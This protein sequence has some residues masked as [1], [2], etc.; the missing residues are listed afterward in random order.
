LT[1]ARLLRF[2]LEISFGPLMVGVVGAVVLFEIV[3]CV[4]AA[5]RRRT[6]RPL[7]LRVHA[8]A[9]AAIGA[10]PIAIGI[11]VHGAR[12]MAMRAMRGE[13]NP[14]GD[15][16]ALASG[17]TAQT[18][19]IAIA[20]GAIALALAFWLAGLALTRGAFRRA[21]AFESG[22]LGG[23]PNP[24]AMIR[25]EQSSPAPHANSPAA[26]VALGLLP[27]AFGAW[28]WTRDVG[29]PFDALET[30]PDEPSRVAIVSRS[31][32]AARA[33]L[34]SAAHLS[35]VAISILAVVAL[36]WIVARARNPAATRPQP[37][38]PTLALAAAFV[39]LAALLAAQARP[40][41]SENATPW[42]PYNDSGSLRAV[43]I[44]TPDLVGPD[45]VEWTRE[46]RVLPD[47]L[48]FES[49][50]VADASGL[51]I[52]L[53]R[54]RA[55]QPGTFNGTALLLV[56]PQ[57]PAARLQSVLQAMLQAGYDQPLFTFAKVEAIQR[58]VLGRLQRV[59]ASAARTTLAYAPAHHDGN[60]GGDRPGD[61]A[62]LR[63]QD[64]AS[65]EPFARRLVALR[66]AGTRVV[67]TI[68]RTDGPTR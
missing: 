5:R 66:H 13:G 12:A 52:A 3:V 24:P 35:N 27:I 59:N 20:V 4:L 33:H 18:Y 30:E 43:D 1:A 50:T 62:P 2:L 67:V 45:R 37:G 25:G 51:R 39:L 19:A 68:D 11:F 40:M 34:E 36:F 8:I 31:L 57:T 22:T 53:D 38:R 15:A 7:A 65:Y 64:F 41:A 42:P 63:P 49:D 17:V 6:G 28:R 9:G 23:F 58:P 29:I 46:V 48:V 61:A 44:Q 54:W 47:R 21:P 26:L 14:L 16:I 55:N 10:L 32:D 56:D 60:G